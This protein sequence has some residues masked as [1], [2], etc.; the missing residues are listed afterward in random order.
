LKA[1]QKIGTSEEVLKQ[2]IDLTKQGIKEFYVYD[3][4]IKLSIEIKRNKQSVS[5]LIEEACAAL[6][7]KKTHF[8]GLMSH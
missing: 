6:P 4:A 2:C 5:Q 3:L 7:D 8:Q 1:F